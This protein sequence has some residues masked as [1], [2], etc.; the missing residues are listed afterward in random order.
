MKNTIKIRPTCNTCGQ[1]IYDDECYCIDPY[2]DF[3]MC[4]S[5]RKSNDEK[6]KEFCDP[7]IKELLDDIFS[8]LRVSTEDYIKEEEIA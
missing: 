3:Y 1:Y 4:E 8:D 6:V 7:V 2:I 5:C